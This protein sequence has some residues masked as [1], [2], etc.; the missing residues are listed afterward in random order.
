MRINTATI[1]S[2]VSHVLTFIYS[3]RHG[4]SDELLTKHTSTEL[5]MSRTDV[6][7]PN[8]KAMHEGKAAQNV[9]AR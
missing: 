9:K 8:I 1:Y 4:E 7:K 5:H 3:V 6:Q 2:I